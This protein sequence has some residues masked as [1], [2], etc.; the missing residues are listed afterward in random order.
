MSKVTDLQHAAALENLYPEAAARIET[1]WA[2]GR[3]ETRS[4]SAASSQ[5][6]CVSVFE[7]IAA[8]PPAARRQLLNAITTAAGIGQPV[9]AAPDICTEVRE[10]R[11]VLR[12]T[13][14]GTPTA[15]DALATWGNAAL[16]IESK[17]CESE[18]GSCG[19][20]R[21][22]KTKPRD[23][24]HRPDEPNRM[25]SDCDGW[26]AVGSDHKPTT[27]PLQA[28]CR[29][30]VRDGRRAPRRYWDVAP[31]LFLPAV[32]AIPRPCP[33]S[34]DGYQLMR[35]LA[36]AHEW[37]ARGPEDFYGFVVCV[38]DA[39]PRAVVLRERFNAFTEMLQP[40]VRAHV[41]LVSYE[42]IAATLDAHGEPLLSSWIV[43]RIRDVFG[44]G[45]EINRAAAAGS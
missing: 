17:F 15:L 26:H 30:T 7:T 40:T 14:G 28:A 31:H 6:L 1:A 29:L 5:A 13:G 12:E 18:F 9:N 22:H 32:T 39:S 27:A 23:Q 44:A 42:Q 4:V 2:R 20:I 24:R 10:Y 34:G 19:Q 8:R 37:P 45:V 16:T 25:V 43:G 21:P 41:G 33:F 36:F 3:L 38:V 11:D 35:N